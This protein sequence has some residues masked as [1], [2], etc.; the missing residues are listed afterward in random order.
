MVK[1]SKISCIIPVYN[2]QKY[3]NGAIDCILNQTLKPDEIII[4]DNSSRDIFI[5]KKIHK[6][7]KLFKIIPSAGLAQTLNFG[8]SIANGKYVSFLEDDDYWPKNYL[9]EIIKKVI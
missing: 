5:N 3:I 1:N 8:V 7:I 9:E 4:V 2:R 6:K